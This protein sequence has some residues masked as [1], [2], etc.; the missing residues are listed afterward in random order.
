MFSLKPDYEESKKRFDAF[1][2]R[3]IIDRPPT[4][5]EIS[6][7][8]TKKNP[9]KKYKSYKKQWLD[10]DYRVESEVS[11]LENKKFL[12]DSIP[13]AFPDMGPGIF[14]AW[15]G[16]HYVF[17]RETAWTKPC[18]K[19]WE[20]DSHKCVLN[21]EHPLLKKQVEFMEKLIEGGRGKF[22]TGLPD[23]HPGGDH[24]AALRDSQNLCFDV[25]EK[26]DRVK[27]K[28]DQSFEDYKRIYNYFYEMLRKEN[29]PISTWINLVHDGKFYVSS[30]DFSCMVSKEIFDDIFLPGIIEECKFYD[31]VIYHLD[32]PG[33][34]HHLDSILSIK[35]LDAVQWIPG[36]GNEGF[37]K[38]IDIYKKI[39]KKQKGI[40]LRIELSELPMVFE[41]LK[42]EGIWFAEIKGVED[43]CTTNEVLSRIKVW[44]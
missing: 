20:K 28:I 30:N 22:I 31:R 3:A 25:L 5:I 4:S 16:C 18:I 26:G 14:S 7:E 24:I 40:D 42:P 36:A 9:E 12:G 39:Q 21:M 37:H 38:W 13:V 35:E 10:I 33:A 41:H 15:C 23:F 19:D 43:E 6:L 17:G 44:R 11:R 27:E 34:L 29:L 2:E 32:G 1:W 8:K